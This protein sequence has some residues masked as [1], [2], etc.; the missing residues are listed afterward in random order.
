M[1]TL[2]SFTNLLFRVTGVRRG[3]GQAFTH[4]RWMSASQQTQM[5]ELDKDVRSSCGHLLWAKMSGSNKDVCRG[6]KCLPWT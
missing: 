4:M 3:D 5:P 6:Q 2:L 1:T